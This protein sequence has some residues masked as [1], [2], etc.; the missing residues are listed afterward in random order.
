MAPQGM[1]PYGGAMPQNQIAGTLPS[2]GVTAGPTRRNPIMMLMPFA[3]VFGGIIISILASIVA[4]L[5]GV[6][7]IGVVCGFLALL[8]D[9]AGLAWFF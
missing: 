5:I 9:L 3:A 6:P 8:L 7:I 1:M 2:G 4:A